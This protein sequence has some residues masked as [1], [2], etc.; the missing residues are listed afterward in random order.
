MSNRNYNQGNNPWDARGTSPVGR[1]F[2]MGNNNNSVRSSNNNHVDDHT[3]PSERHHHLIQG[4]SNQNSTM[5]P[6]GHYHSTTVNMTGAPDVPD[7]ESYSYYDNWMYQTGAVGSTGTSGGH[8]GHYGHQNNQ[9]Q[10][11]RGTFNNPIRRW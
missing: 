1:Q 10:V 7:G 8:G 11:R 5:G 9:G 6:G 3:H 2:R 4:N